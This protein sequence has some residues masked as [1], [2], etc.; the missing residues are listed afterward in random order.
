MINNKNCLAVILARGGSKGIPKKNIYNINDHPL[1]SYSIEAAKNA[2]KI[3][4]IVVSSDSD[5][6]L[7][8]SRKYGVD[9]VI[10]RPKHL[11]NDR[12]TSADALHHAVL[13]S[14]KIFKKN[15]DYI[16]ELPCVSPLRDH[17]DINE[18]LNILCTNKYDSVV[19]YVDTG[20]KHPIRLKRIKKNKITNFCKDYK[21]AKWGSIRQDFE[22]CY[23]RNGA[24]Y[25]MSRDC[26]VNHKSRWGK[27]SFP[28]VMSDQKSVN[29]DTKFDL[30]IAK[31]LIE[32]GY[33]KN[34][35]KI[36]SNV[37]KNIFNKKRKTLLVTTPTHILNNF[38]DKL[39][40]D[41]N[42]IF[43]FDCSSKDIK[44]ILPEINYWI[45]SPS[46]TYKIDGKFLKTAKKLK[47][48][49]T[50]STGI[51]HL[52]TNYLHKSKIEL[53]S[54]KDHP[55]LKNIKASSEFTFGLILDS[56]RNLSVGTKLS[57]NGFWRQ[58]EDSLR[59]MQ[60]FGKKIG[61]IGYGRIGSN[62][63]KYARSFGMKCSAY[64]PFKKKILQKKGLYVDLSRLIKES[65]L[66]LVSVHLN[67]KTKNLVNKK[68][69]NKMHKNAIL[70]NTSRGE[71]VDEKALLNSLKKN[72]IKSAHLDV[73]T[74]EQ[75]QNLNNHPLINFSKNSR[76]LTI[77]PHMAGLTFES[78]NMAAEII[79][80]LLKNVE[81]KNK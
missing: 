6:I 64:D 77:T 1:I 45:C 38:K 5:E 72:L 37:S 81:K 36:F 47:A 2:E 16:I 13:E 12:A 33:C 62:V 52:D 8:I 49:F 66:I 55:K 35:P 24:I 10:K 34:Y 78:E 68:F 53:Y 73:I 46:P 7:K 79:L 54:I 23:I 60:L 58:Q 74:N 69:L 17:D 63:E 14:E 50:P 70:V 21:E 26:I 28:Y 32:N 27:K 51:T 65:D 39:N 71:V 43:A 19:S 75:S 15:F 44:K 48:I 61:I 3:D 56:L 30:L 57:K 40:K 20:E 42:C 76:K 29:I 22:P 4:K 59:G 31:M 11:S 67:D 80:K 41:Y 9:K 18:A 25:S